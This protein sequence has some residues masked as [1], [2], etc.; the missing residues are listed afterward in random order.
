MRRFL[1]RRTRR[2]PQLRDS[3]SRELLWL[4]GIKGK[5][6]RLSR[7]CYATTYRLA[8]RTHIRN[9][10]HFSVRRARDM[11]DTR[12][13][14]ARAVALAPRGGRGTSRARC[15]GPAPPRSRHAPSAARGQRVC[16]ALRSAPSRKGRVSALSSGPRWRP[17]GAIVARA[18]PP[19]ISSIGMLFRVFLKGYA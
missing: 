12:P 17:T 5:V 10:S 7:L 11:R 1:A 9:A 19:K 6:S 13:L 16:A 2:Q 18:V 4:L 15:R 8:R 3:S 14:S